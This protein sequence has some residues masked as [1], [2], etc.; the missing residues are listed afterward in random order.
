MSWLSWFGRKFG[1]MPVDETR[2][3]MV[4]VES[5]GLDAGLDALLA[6]AAIAM[7]V[8]W[9]NGRLTVEPADSF[10]VLL[11]Q[12]DIVSSRT[13]IMLHGIGVAAQ[14]Q[15]QAPLEA[16]QA[17]CSF[18]GSSPLLAFHAAFDKTMVERQLDQLG[19][20]GLQNPWVDVEHLCGVTHEGVRSRSLDDWMAYFSIDC[21]V[22]H[23]AA[24]DAFAQ[25]EVLQRIWPKMRQM[26]KNWKAV[27]RIARQRHWLRP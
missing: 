2:W 5:S 27:E 24:A 26:G 12:P 1:A 10:E 11:Y 16:M 17:F 4:D 23:Q 3:V 14:R 20:P 19:M 8:D 18:V 22:R 21:A 9:P 13:N 15:G 25:C 7:R 6:I